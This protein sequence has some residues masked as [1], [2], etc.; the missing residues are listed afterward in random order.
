MG[1]H[2]EIMGMD[3]EAGIRVMAEGMEIIWERKFFIWPK[4]LIFF[5]MGGS[6]VGARIGAGIGGMLGSTLGRK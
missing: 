6:M 5:R 3:T 4:N 1:I 2:M